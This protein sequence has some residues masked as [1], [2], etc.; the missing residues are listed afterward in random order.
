MEFCSPYCTITEVIFVH[1]VSDWCPHQHWNVFEVEQRCSHFS[2][3][4][5]VVIREKAMAVAIS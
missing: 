2:L 1:D 3:F 5:N 4:N